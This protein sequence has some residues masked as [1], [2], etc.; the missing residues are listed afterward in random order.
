MS[1]SKRVHGT[2]SLQ[3]FSDRQPSSGRSHLHNTG[4]TWLHWCGMHHCCH[5]VH[6]CPRPQS[7][8]LLNG[9]PLAGPEGPAQGPC[10]CVKLLL[11][12]GL[13]CCRQLQLPASLVLCGQPVC[14]A[15]SSTWIPQG[16]Q[17][18]AL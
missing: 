1:S 6:I 5:Q 4:L 15:S 2:T 12:L 10:L 13:A 16:V 8:Q 7:L 18:L 14:T 3:K 17:L 9:G 11:P